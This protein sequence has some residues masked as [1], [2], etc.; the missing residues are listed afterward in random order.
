M[1]ETAR[2]AAKKAEAKGDLA[3][4]EKHLR[5]AL[6][7]APD[8]GDSMF[9]LAELLARSGR[10]K[11]A[12]PFYEK[13]LRAFPGNPALLNAI[14]VVAQKSGQRDKAISLWR[15][16]QALQP[17]LAAPLVNIA[18]ALREAGD[19]DGA[20]ASF[21]KALTL[22]PKS[23]DAHYNLGVTYNHA[24]RYD[25][26]IEHL[27]L[28]IR[29]RPDN[30]RA[31]AMLARTAQAVCD[32]DRLDDAMPML[33]AEVA[34]AR[35]GKPCAVTPWFSLRL[36]FSLAD[37]KAIAEVAMRGPDTAARSAKQDF[38]LTRPR[39]KLTIGYISSDFRNH[40]IMQLT[41]G[42][43]RRHDRNRFRVI[44]YPVKPP[45]DEGRKTLDADCDLVRDL[46]SLSD[47]EAAA[48]IRGDRVDI[49]VDISGIS[50]FMRLGI[51]ALRPAPL[52]LSYLNY[53]GTI[54]GALY[55]YIVGDPVVTPVEHAPDYLE[56]I[57][58]LP[59]SYQINNCDQLIGSKP[60]RAAE[61]L[62]EDAFVFA[63]FS[64]P[65]KI[66]RGVFA[67][68]MNVLRQVPGSV[69]WLFSTAALV[70]ANLRR[71]AESQDIDPGRL[72]FAGRRVKAEHLGRLQ[73]ADLHFDTGTYGAHTTGSDALWAGVPLITMRGDAFPARVG[74]SMLQAIGL[75][76][77]ITPDWE[78]YERL[79][80]DLAQQPE[81]LM[82]VRETLA[83]NRLQ[84]PLFDTARTVRDLE[85]LYET[86][87]RRR[88]EGKQ[89]API[90][91]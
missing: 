65:E 17:R 44:A 80:I 85:S 26:A 34:K 87:W 75:S 30:A 84:T 91:V 63:C 88:V 64:I 70:Q 16:V 7:A 14:A 50:E 47:T 83:K 18:L 8:D 5:F 29:A 31:I 77:L 86:M 56:A 67:R 38:D 58:Q 20:M 28:A 45:S 36:P 53:A 23:F 9:A 68:W 22:E 12:E 66:E 59:H 32:W 43:Y 25:E 42:L 19:L 81:K 35:E 1:S 79:A 71:A 46:T 51:L 78:S 55:D 15:Q 49:L 89:P 54:S 11:E 10:M 52:Q 21:E 61:G 37:R 72:V 74:A 24:H 41:A 48:A 40:P 6:K 62:P 90:L 69:L 76:D 2:A 3:A 73:L 57:A 4:A 39:E 82:A 33:R 27:T 13:L 60:D